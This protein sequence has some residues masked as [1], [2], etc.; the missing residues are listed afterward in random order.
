MY[1]SE[2]LGGVIFLCLIKTRRCLMNARICTSKVS[3][4]ARF[5]VSTLRYAYSI[6]PLANLLV[7]QAQRLKH[8]FRLARR[9]SVENEVHQLPQLAL[10]VMPSTNLARVGDGAVK[11][12]FHELC[13]LFSRFHFYVSCSTRRHNPTV[14]RTAEKHRRRLPWR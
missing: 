7:S 3:F 4:T 12:A 10:A 5:R 9:R 2:K 1:L 6:P 13:N 8:L 14:K 11:L